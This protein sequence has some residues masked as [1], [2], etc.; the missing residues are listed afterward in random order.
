MNDAIIR[1]RTARRAGSQGGYALMTVVLMI[2]LTSLGVSALLGLMFTS[3]ATQASSAKEERELRAL[4]TAMDVVLNELRF[5]PQ[6]PTTAACG[7]VMTAWTVDNGTS[8]PSD[9]V[10]VAIECTGTTNTERG[11]TGDQVRLVGQDGY[12][13]TGGALSPTTSVTGTATD[14]APGFLEDSPRNWTPGQWIGFRVR[15][16]S[17]NGSVQTRTITGNTK[18]RL[19]VS[20]P[21]SVIPLPGICCAPGFGSGY[22]ISSVAWT[23]WSWPTGVGITTS[24]LQ[25]SKPNLVHG[26]AA[27]LQFGSGVTVRNSAAVLTNGVEGTASSA[28]ATT[29][30]DATRS[31]TANQWAGYQLRILAGTGAGQTRT[32]SSNTTNALTVSAAWAPTPNATSIYGIV[33]ADTVSAVE[34]A[35]EYVQGNLGPGTGGS[36]GQ[37]SAAGPMLIRDL[38][39]SGSPQCSPTGGIELDDEPTD[40][41]AGFPRPSARPSPPPPAEC[42]STVITLA[43]GRY[44]ATDMTRLN[45]LL[46]GSLPNCNDKTFH[47]LPGVHVF[48]GDQLVFNRPGSFFVM[49]APKGWTDGPTGTGVQ[50]NPALVNDPTQA[51]C[52]PAQSGAT[53]VL[54]PQFRLEHRTSSPTT[55]GRV[56]MCPAFSGFVGQPPLPAIYQETSYANRMVPLTSPQPK[57]F[58]CANV[59][60]LDSVEDLGV[61]DLP[62]SA[63]RPDSFPNAAD[64]LPPVPNQVS[65]TN[66]VGPQC[67]VGRTFSAT[68]DSVDPRPLTSARLLVRGREAVTVL[69][70]PDTPLN[71]IT[72]RR[73]MVTVRKGAERICTTAAQPGIGNGDWAASINLLTGSCAVP[74]GF[75]DDPRTPIPLFLPATEQALTS[76]LLSEATLDVTQ[77]MTFPCVQVL[78]ACILPLQQSYTVDGIEL[79][80]NGVTTSMLGP[81]TNVAGDPPF[82]RGF[83]NPGGVT[84]AGIATPQMPNNST[85]SGNALVTGTGPCELYLLCLIPVPEGVQLPMRTGD[86]PFVHHLDLGTASVQ[87]P[88]EYTSR[89]IDPNLSA[90]GLQLRLVPDHCPSAPESKCLLWAP[91][92][93]IDLN[94]LRV[95]YQGSP[96]KVQV[97]L[98]TNQGTRCVEATARIG[99]TTEVFVDLME[100]NRIVPGNRSATDGCDDIVI[101]SLA[102]L[103]LTPTPA[104][105]GTNNVGLSVRFEVPCLEQPTANWKCWPMLNGDA[106]YQVRPPSIDNVS[107]FV[108]SDTIT[109]APPSSR[110][111]INARTP[112]T[113]VS[114][115]SFNVYGKVWMPRANLDVLWTGDVTEGVP[116]V[117]DELVVGS[118]GSWISAPPVRS[119]PGTRYLVCCTA[120]DATSREVRLVATVPASGRKL[121]VRAFFDDR[122]SSGG[123]ADG[124]RMEIRDWQ[125]CDEGRET[126]C[127]LN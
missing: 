88:S 100:A 34:V 26:G 126:R 65:P 39:G 62:G 75:F 86:R 35:G 49:G 105:S 113:G 68:V 45:G 81:V 104:G 83:D 80:T 42:T 118:L 66:P 58:S 99:S 3:V 17:G 106:V 6:N 60:G 53:F 107:L 25:S 123:A 112:G 9:D 29:L 120:E 44:S 47:F 15:I 64:R 56:S 61:L 12:P 119:A 67:R 57:P 55:G 8:T 115:S 31:W 51:L 116:L 74:R 54:P 109:A 93:G 79:I 24:G 27:P 11:S 84:G 76:A 28:T 110:I 7:N 127:V 70:G 20:P 37:L 48:T 30:T 122:N 13:A 114:T 33:A 124:F 117:E 59:P 50:G 21:F 22:S 43:P 46:N 16:T 82:L 4:D 36:C 77:Y 10:P 2:G 92:E 108:S 85:V 95:F 40:A 78:L 102:D 121:F 90:L 96:L 23:D 1:R 52:D 101:D 125:T 72:D 98:R 63:N 14:G 69:G 71:A 91:V 18:N 87:I 103:R 41:I 111:S 89:S 73:I 38:G 19:T 32:I 94:F 5:N 97:A